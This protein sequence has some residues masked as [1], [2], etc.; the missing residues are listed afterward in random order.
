MKVFIKKKKSRNNNNN[1]NNYNGINTFT[2][3]YIHIFKKK[4]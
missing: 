1:N 3:K 2:N 4:K